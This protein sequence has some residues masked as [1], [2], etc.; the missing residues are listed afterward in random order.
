VI[1]G[2]QAELSLTVLKAV[3]ERYPVVGVI[4]SQFRGYRAPQAWQR[5]LSRP[6]PAQDIERFA[7]EHAIPFFVM[8][9]E[10][11][12]ALAAFIRR[13]QPAVGVIAKMVQLLPMEIVSLFP[14]GIINVHP[15]LLPRYRGPIPVFWT[16]YH[17]ETVSGLTI[18]LV[19]KGADTGDILKQKELPLSFGEGAEE[20]NRRYTAEA[21][22]LVLEALEDLAGGTAVPRSQRMLPCP[23]RARFLKPN[24]DPI[25]WSEW[26]VERIYQVLRGADSIL[27]LLPQRPFPLSLCEWR[28][29]GF[30]R[31]P[32]SFPGRKIVIGFSGCYIPRRDGRIF[33]K[34]RFSLWQF[35][36]GLK[37]FVS[38]RRAR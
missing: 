31:R 17:Q 30:D 27:D 6:S 33:L 26:S 3:A 24:E 5:W 18:H 37:D 21:P 8:V 4:E 35:R 22:A 29:V 36:C 9:P 23:F 34:P 11:L 20:F 19:D 7:R 28:V 25:D 14:L 13:V 16:L 2:R 12:D 38:R 1:F 15:S 32:S 10:R